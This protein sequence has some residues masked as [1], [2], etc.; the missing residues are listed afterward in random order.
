MWLFFLILAITSNAR[1]VITFP[2]ND[3]TGNNIEIQTLPTTFE[4]DGFIFD[5]PANRPLRQTST[6]ITTTTSTTTTVDPQF[7]QCVATC[8]TTNEYNPVCGSDQID[9]KN[10]GQLSCASMCGKDVSLSHYGRC[11]TTKIRG[12]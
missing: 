12:R 1:N 4:V 7:D 9:Y 5:G 10:P 2:Q 11:T 3:L 8:R 6:T